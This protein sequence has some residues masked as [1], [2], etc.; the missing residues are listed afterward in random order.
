MHTMLYTDVRL[1]TGWPL[2]ILHYS[3]YYLGVCDSC[4]SIHQAS[5]VGCKHA[6]S[7]TITATDTAEKVVLFTG[8]TQA[9]T[10]LLRVEA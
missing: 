3:C 8:Y 4:L 10:S 7:M 1:D 2:S 5:L 9:Y 6:N